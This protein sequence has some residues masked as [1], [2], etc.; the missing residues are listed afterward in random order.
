MCVMSD[1]DLRHIA[2]SLRSF[3]HPGEFAA[4]HRES[5]QGL[6]VAV[7]GVGACRLPLE[8]RY[9][10]AL[11]GHAV[12]SPFGY[13]D[14]TLRD[15]S[16]RDSWEIPA[17]AITLDPATWSTRLERGVRTIARALRFP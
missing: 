6:G 3:A 8:E 15:R 17:P 7:E 13:R 1:P 11:V 16:V 4:S 2:E 5:A 9:V 14:Q 10:E 12:R